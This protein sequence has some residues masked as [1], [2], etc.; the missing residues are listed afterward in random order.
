VVV[1]GGGKVAG[2]SRAGLQDGG[3]VCS[4]KAGR[5]AASAMEGKDDGG[6]MEGTE[7]VRIEEIL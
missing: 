3:K 5:L 7:G 1:G 4:I 6:G 2:Y